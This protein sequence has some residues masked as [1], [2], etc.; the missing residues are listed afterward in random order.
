[1]SD[2]TQERAQQIVLKLLKIETELKELERET[3]W[4]NRKMIL[5]AATFLE[6]AKEMAFRAR[7]A[8][9][10]EMDV[11]TFTGEIGQYVPEPTEQF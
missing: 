9:G 10:I 11:N 8:V 2:L 5:K 7:S 3:A 1:M 4:N 6:A